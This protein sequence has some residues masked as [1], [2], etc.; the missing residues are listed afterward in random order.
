MEKEI[1][2]T[3]LKVNI[4]TDKL[5]KLRYIGGTSLEPSDTTKRSHTSRV[6]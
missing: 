3:K 5:W 2:M 4:V 6:G 1:K